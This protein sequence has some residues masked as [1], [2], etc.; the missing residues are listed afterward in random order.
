VAALERLIENLEQ[1][2]RNL[3]QQPNPDPAQIEALTNR[4]AARK[5]ELEQL[6]FDLDA[7]ESDY[8]FFC[9]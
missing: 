7:M 2:L 4:I 1:Q 6:R 5:R 8:T 3:Q 9:S